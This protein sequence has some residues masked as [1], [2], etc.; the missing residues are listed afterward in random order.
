M[1]RTQNLYSNHN[2]KRKLIRLKTTAQLISIQIDKTK[3]SKGL[4][5]LSVSS[6]LTILL[7]AVVYSYWNNT[8]HFKPLVFS[9]GIIFLLISLKFINSKNK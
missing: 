3:I 9:S 7:V 4:Q 8:Y 6:F 5:V 1:A 2:S